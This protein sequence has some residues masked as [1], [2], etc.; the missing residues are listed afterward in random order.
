MAVMTR[1]ALY[2]RI[3]SMRR[4]YGIQGV[5]DPYAFA[6]AQAIPLAL[7]RF[8]NERLRGIL[9]R[10]GAY[11]GVI[12]DTRLT[13]AEQRFTLTHEIVH[14]ELHCGEQGGS[15]FQNNSGEYQADEGAAELLMPYRD[16]IPRVAAARRKLLQ[17]PTEALTRLA[18]HY[19]LNCEYIRRR[20]ISLDH[21][22]DLYRKGT[23]VCALEPLSYHRRQE[24]GVTEGCFLGKKSPV[25]VAGIDIFCDDNSRLGVE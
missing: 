8:T 23:P 13:P 18:L 6:G 14:F 15:A 10:T 7:H 2:R 5:F 11:H 20:M 21:E 1:S 22:L 24:L 25:S 9:V 19:Q 16:F 3:D 4:K 12:L 17:N